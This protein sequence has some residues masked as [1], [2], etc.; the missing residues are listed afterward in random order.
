MSCINKN[1]PFEFKEI[2]ALKHTVL[3]IGELNAVYPYR[4]TIIDSIMYIMDL[5]GGN[6][7]FFHA[8]SYPSL[9]S[10][11]SFGRK[12]N[13]PT[14][15]NRASTIVNHNDS[16]FIYDG[17]LSKVVTPFFSNDSIT[18]LTVVDKKKEYPNSLDFAVIGN[19]NYIFED[20]TGQNRLIQVSEK[21]VYNL[22]AIP[23]EDNQY[24][25]D[26]YIGYLWRAFIDYSPKLNKIVAATQ[27]GQAIEIYD[28]NTSKSLVAI[29]KDGVPRYEKEGSM[30][31][32]L[33]GFCD[34]KWIDNK[35]YALYSGR[36]M[37]ELTKYLD[38]TGEQLPNGGNIIYV[39][40]ENGKPIVQYNLDKFID[41]FCFDKNSNCIIG[42]S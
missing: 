41:G 19:K 2:K 22:F 38:G 5:H 8:Y 30:G 10:I 18:D 33:E 42:I 7:I 35:I 26:K 15:M 28:L 13:G 9:K 29:G 12:G 4:I 21:G 20:M 17:A 40:D 25:K 14:E 32:Y 39:F 11:S 6:N 16:L 23:G 3:D 36:T 37:A 24:L 1:A 34:V 31:S 27:N